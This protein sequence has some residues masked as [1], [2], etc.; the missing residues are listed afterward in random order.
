M[1]ALLGKQWD[2]PAAAGECPAAAV[3]GWPSV[4]DWAHHESIP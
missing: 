3:T 2:Q 1:C 4:G